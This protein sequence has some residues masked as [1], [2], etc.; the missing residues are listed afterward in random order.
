LTR[1]AEVNKTSIVYGG[2]LGQ[3]A[4]TEDKDD[5]DENDDSVGFGV[6]VV[7]SGHRPFYTAEE[8]K[9]FRTLGLEPGIKLLGFKDRTELAFEDN[10]KHSQFIYPDEMAYSGSKRTFSA[11]L[12]SMIKKKK[13]GLALSVTRRNSTPLFCAILPQAE[14]TDEGGWTDPAGFH[15]IPLPFADD[16]RAAPIEEAFRASDEIKDA[17]RAWIDKLS[18]KNGTYPPDSYPNPALA[19]HNA[20]LQASAF[21]EEFDPES[22]EDLTEPKIEMI[23]KRA[24]S[25]IRAWKVALVNDKS[26]NTVIA[27]PGS[28]R[29][30]DVSVDEAEIR[31]KCEVGALEKLRV[32]QLKEFLKAKGLPVSGKKAD[33]IERVVEWFDSH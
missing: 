26:A 22:F 16:I 3:T 31:S 2:A 23:H 7:Q 9:S 5:E 11:L 28:K 8:I 10:I 32:D 15:L 29:K 30:A 12:R 14:K 17:A 13:I 25:L 4:G 6:R 20:Q 18:V 27:I 19:Y 24:G 33:L 1:Q 21:R